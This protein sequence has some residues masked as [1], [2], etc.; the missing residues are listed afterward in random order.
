[1]SYLD[2]L[3]AR[4][5]KSTEAK[6]VRRVVR[7]LAAAGT[8]VVAVWDGEEETPALAETRVVELAADLDQLHLYTASGSW[9]FIVNGNDWDALSDYTTDLEPALGPVCDWAAT[10]W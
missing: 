10:K 1:M 3:I 4:Y 5:R 2:E 6:I 8:P 9:V 7:A